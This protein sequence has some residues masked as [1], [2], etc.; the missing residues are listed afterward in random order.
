MVPNG[1]G[2][3]EKENE[4]N[5]ELVQFVTA[6]HRS[7]GYPLE[8]AIVFNKTHKVYKSKSDEESDRL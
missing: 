8:I 2:D 4:T 7:I 3:F 6:G 5:T 1:K